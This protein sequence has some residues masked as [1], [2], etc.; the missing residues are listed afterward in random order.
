MNW[1]IEGLDGVY[2][3]K[4]TYY[5]SLVV[6]FEKCRAHICTVLSNLNLLLRN[7]R[8]VKE[9]LVDLCIPQ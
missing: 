6:Y 3:I 5:S 8:I 4:D 2:S 7:D 1:I 9:Q